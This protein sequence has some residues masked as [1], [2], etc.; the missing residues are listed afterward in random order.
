MKQPVKLLMSWNI[1][2]GREEAYF[3]FI[4]RE[5]P[6]TLLHAG[7]HLTD[8]W[9]TVYGHNWP[10]AIMGFISE[11]LETMHAFMTSDDWRNIRQKLFF[12]VQDYGQKVIA[13]QGGF[14]L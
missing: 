3:D 5:F 13:A 14:Q 6:A 11:D 4:T 12:Y 1:R 9:Y 7:L 10:Q 2:A 8:A